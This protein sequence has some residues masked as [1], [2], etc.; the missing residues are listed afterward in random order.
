MTTV[1]TYASLMEAL[2]AWREAKRH[3]DR[4]P[5][6]VHPE[7]TIEQMNRDATTERGLAAAYDAHMAGPVDG[8][9]LLRQQ[10]AQYA[11]E[12]DEARAE[13]QRLRAEIAVFANERASQADRF[14]VPDDTTRAP[15][16]I[17]WLLVSEDR[18]RLRAALNP[19]GSTDV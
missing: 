12:R 7:Q 11:R 8:I 2:A 15:D 17:A 9:E 10:A 5:I 1:D 6:A 18:D 14:G 4:I 19:D 13:A 3:W 16:R